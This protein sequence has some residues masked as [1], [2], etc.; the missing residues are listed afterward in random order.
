MAI[1]G[2][3]DTVSSCS[4]VAASVGDTH[5]TRVIN[6]LC[7]DFGGPTRLGYAPIACN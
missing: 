5:G 1:A 7:R 4:E 6:S 3:G 2:V